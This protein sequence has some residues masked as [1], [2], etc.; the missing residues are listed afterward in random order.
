MNR[1]MRLSIRNA[2]E[3]ERT[4]IQTVTL[5]AYEEYA[6]VMPHPFWEA[7]RRQLLLTL[8][9]EGPVERIVAESEGTVVGSVL[10]YPKLSHA[11]ADVEVDVGWPEVRLLAVVPAVR[12]QGV[13]SALMDECERRARR[14]GATVLGL[15]TMDVMQEAVRLYEHRGFIR[16]PK[17]DFHLAPSV[18]VKGYRLSLDS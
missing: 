2:R 10:L 8:D 12:G 1:R 7:Y 6:T 4:T 15:H 17:L 16:A 13:G 18:V 11:Y 14:A 3:D 9:E 5:A